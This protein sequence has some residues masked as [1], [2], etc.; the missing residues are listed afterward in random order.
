MDAKILYEPGLSYT[1]DMTFTYTVID[2][3][4]NLATATVT[5]AVS[6]ADLSDHTPV[7]L[8]DAALSNPGVP[9]IIPVLDNDYDLD[10]DL[11][12]V[13][14]VAP[15]ANG[16]AT[17]LS[18]GT[19]EYL[20]DAEFEGVE[21]FSYTITDGGH[22]ADALVSITVRWG[23]NYAPVAVDDNAL[24]D[25]EHPIVIPVMDNDYDPDGDALSVIEVSVPPKYGTVEIN[26]DNTISYVADTGFTGIDDFIYRVSDG[27]LNDA[28]LVT[29]NVF[30]ANHDPIAVDDEAAGIPGSTVVV[31]VLANDSD[32]DG[33]PLTITD[34]TTP[35]YGDTVIEDGGQSIRYVPAPDFNGV[36]SFFY[37]IVDGRGGSAMAMVT[38]GYNTPPVAE[39]DQLSGE[40]GMSYDID[41][42]A[43]DSDPDG[44]AIEITDIG[45]PSAGTA[46]LNSDGTVHVKVPTDAQG[47]LTF[48]YTIAD[49]WGDTDQATVTVS[50]NGQPVAVDDS[51]S[52][53]VNKDTRVNVLVNDSDP[54]GDG[55][56]I[57]A[58]GVPSHGTAELDRGKILYTPAGDYIGSDSFTYT[59]SDGRGGSATATVS[60][61]VYNNTPAPSSDNVSVCYQTAETFNVLNNDS[62]D[63]GD[64]LSVIHVS[65]PSNGALEWEADGTTTYT[66]ADGWSGIETLVYTV[67]DGRGGE[68]SAEVVLTVYPDVE[69]DAVDDTATTSS[70]KSVAIDVLANDTATE[71]HPITIDYI[72]DAD[73][74][75]VSIN[76]DDTITYTPSDPSFTGTDSFSYI[77]SDGLGRVD[78]ATVTVTIE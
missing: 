10:G 5:V 59:I 42:L 16:T 48:V 76:L 54:D 69:P 75:N 4:G 39:D 24:G 2:G 21:T 51:A 67:A 63:D 74:G 60:V 40:A 7:A 61:D 36:D 15:T 1:G 8:D 25:N 73:H 53:S 72:S 64:A 44:N 12:S 13:V 14:S 31:D 49:E 19:I 55:L 30:A 23:G 62:D 71:C 17:L 33:D 68:A 6:P 34:V 20:P 70:N 77:I 27:S 9:V 57:D 37:A 43:N 41:V 52:T 32:P 35:Y 50:V 18:D 46:T 78:N 3:N 26:A 58:V 29:V 66:P 11:L 38:I 47:D 65:A 45:S 28:A 22:T 56:T